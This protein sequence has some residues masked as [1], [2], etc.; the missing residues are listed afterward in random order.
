M[1][2]A[3]GQNFADSLGVDMPPLSIEESVR[4]VLKQVCPPFYCSIRLNRVLS[5]PTFLTNEFRS[6]QLRGQPALARS[7][8]M[9]EA[10]CY[11]KTKY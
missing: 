6:M 2:T 5:V 11:G 1:K 10:S 3:N 8:P 7:Y 9:T 4:G